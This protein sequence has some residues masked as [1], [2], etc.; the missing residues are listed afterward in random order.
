VLAGGVDVAADVQA[1]L[2][3]VLAGQAAGDLL[4]GLQGAHSALAD[5]IRGP[6]AGVSGELQHG[7]LA[8]AA[9]FQQ[10]AAGVL[11]G[12]VL[13]PGDTGD[14][15]Q[16]DGDGAAELQGQRIRGGGRD[17]GL[18]G[19][20]GVA[21]GADQAAQRPLRLRRPVR[22]RVGL[23]AVLEVPEQVLVMPISA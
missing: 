13:R 3:G 17:R 11:G 22:V 19:V 12:G 2:G 14:L 9:E 1:V 10:L 7:V 5:V 21:P 15:R 20:A 6:D 4:L 16:A 8:V 23:G 18:A